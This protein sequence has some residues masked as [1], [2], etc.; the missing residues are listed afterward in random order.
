MKKGSQQ[1]MKVPMMTP[2]VMVALR[3]VFTLGGLMEVSLS[4]WL[5]LLNIC[6]IDL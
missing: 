1:A 3:S 6:D 4:L 5:I 2:K